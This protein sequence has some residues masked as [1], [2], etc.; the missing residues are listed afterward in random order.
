M[1]F[2]FL[3]ALSLLLSCALAQHGP[4]AHYDAP[5]PYSYAYAVA[6]DYR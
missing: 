3:L 2:R 5:R 1:L 6:D 4:A